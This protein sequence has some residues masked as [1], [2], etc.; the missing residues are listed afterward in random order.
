MDDRLEL[1]VA[2]LLALYLFLAISVA[3]WLLLAP[4]LAGL[5]LAGWFRLRGAPPD[6]GYDRA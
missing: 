5:V 4:S 1:A 2:G 6:S 3:D